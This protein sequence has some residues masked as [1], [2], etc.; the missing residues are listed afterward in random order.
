[1]RPA[2]RVEWLKLRRSRTA[3]ATA[4]VVCLSVPLTTVGMVVGA[5][6]G[7]AGGAAAGKL[8]MLTADATTTGHLGLAAQLLTVVALLG[9]GFLSTWVFGREFSDG[10][11]GGLFALPVTRG[12]I[13]G[14]KMLLAALVTVAMTTTA[15]CLTILGIVVIDGTALDPDAAGRAWA[16][17]GGGALTSLLT[18]VFGLVA[19]LARSCLAG[20]GALIAT[21][22]AAQLVV[23]F[24]G[25]LWFPF[26]VP[27]LW[28]GA[29]GTDMAAAVGPEHLATVPVFAA[30]VT[31]AT[32]RTWN[33][34]RLD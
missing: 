1:M 19:S 29:G 11:V 22:A 9:G 33:R 15:G 25:G 20:V 30:L 13:A 7:R 31:W 10:T 5:R 16:L 28:S 8:E 6:S 21:V 2:T 26:A 34:L 4:F 17:L 27:A 24:G 23:T 3:R 12:R 18:P 32:I 14:A